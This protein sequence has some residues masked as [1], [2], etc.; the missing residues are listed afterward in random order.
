MALT[1][2]KNTGIN[3]TKGS[4]ISLIKD[5]GHRLQK[6]CVGLNWGGIP[7]SGLWQVL[8]SKSVDLDV[9]VGQFDEEG[10]VID[11]VCFRK[12][13]S[14]DN[15]IKHSG[16]DLVGDK[17]GDDGCDN[18]VISIDLTKVDR[19][20]KQL[21][22]FLNSYSGQDF[23]AIPY[24]KIRL[25]EGSPGKVQSVFASFNLSS[26]DKFANHV[27]MVMAKLIKKEDEWVFN[28]IGEA[29]P[30]ANIKHTVHHIKDH[31]LV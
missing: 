8:G 15:A 27:S 4:S 9:S 13:T 3:L 19:N 29:I 17:Y 14:Y 12:L 10:K 16:D 26:E 21:V 31:F 7:R 30:V 5:D 2:T 20:T 1:L 6:F 23:A 24:S 28:S 18:E 11:V 22:F 25:Y